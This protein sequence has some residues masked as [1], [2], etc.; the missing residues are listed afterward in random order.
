MY[1]LPFEGEIDD[2]KV[3][4][5]KALLETQACNQL[6]KYLSDREHCTSQCQDFL[7]R[8]HYHPILINQ[9]ISEYQKL[10][11]LDDSRFVKILISSLI[12]RRKSKTHIITKLHELHLPSALWRE[13]LND[14]YIPDNSLEYV[15]ESI[16]KLKI[17]YHELPEYKQKEKIFASLMRK[18]FDLEVINEAWRYS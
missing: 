15:K 14:M 18:G 1:P 11:Y 12:E 17:R 10:K 16:L 5:L 6:L 3:A 2:S 7:K 8:K 9:I 13:T 4:E